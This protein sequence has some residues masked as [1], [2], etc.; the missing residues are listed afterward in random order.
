MP[1]TRIHALFLGTL[2]SSVVGASAAFAQADALTLEELFDYSSGRYNL[3]VATDMLYQ[4]VEGKYEH[5]DTTMSVVVPYVLLVGPPGVIPGESSTG[6]ASPQRV[7]RDGLGDIIVSV[8]QEFDFSSLPDTSFDAVGK[9]KLATAS[10]SRGLGTGENDYY[11]EFG[12]TQTLA[13]GWSVDLTG[14]RRFVESAAET[15]L[16]DVWYGS[17]EPRW[18]LNQDYSI[19]ASLDYR[20]AASP[21]SGEVLESSLMAS[22]FFDDGWKLTLYAV[23][24][25]A[26][27]SEDV[28]GGLVLRKRFSL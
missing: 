3:P 9:V 22:R 11:A 12:V 2:C 7:S 13:P 16:R 6:G 14:G 19:A 21:S 10:A 4:G 8:D 18:R 26:P 20:Q 1:R 25:F 24:G 15:G 27:G 5:G 28:G 17:V 23:K